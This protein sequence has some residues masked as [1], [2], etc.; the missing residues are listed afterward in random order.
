MSAIEEVHV[1]SLINGEV[2][3]GCNMNI[4]PDEVKIAFPCLMI[5]DTEGKIYWSMFIGQP[6]ELKIKTSWVV[7]HYVIDDE[8]IVKM[9]RDRVSK[10]LIKTSQSKIYIPQ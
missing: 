9:Y 1:L 4:G 2:V 10:L 5:K 8:N 7:T 6:V 3:V